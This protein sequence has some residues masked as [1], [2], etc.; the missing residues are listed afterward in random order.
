MVS[1]TASSPG[2]GIDNRVLAARG[3]GGRL[4]GRCCHISANQETHS[5]GKGSDE[6]LWEGPGWVAVAVAIAFPSRGTAAFSGPPCHKRSIGTSYM[7]PV[8]A[9]G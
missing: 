3:V 4:L 8:M 1:I 5:G 6:G 2:V 7:A 9:L